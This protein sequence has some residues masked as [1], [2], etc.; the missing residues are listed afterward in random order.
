MYNVISN[1][2]T[3]FSIMSNLQT[4]YYFKLYFQKLGQHIGGKWLIYGTTNNHKDNQ[5]QSLE[6]PWI[7]YFCC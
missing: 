6:L 1:N 7:S 4:E 3:V 2:E 5:L